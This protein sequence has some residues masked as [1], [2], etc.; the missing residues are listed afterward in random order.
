MPLHFWRAPVRSATTAS[1]GRARN[2]NPRPSPSGPSGRRTARLVEELR[3]RPR[4]GGERPDFRGGRQEV[5]GQLL[6]LVVRPDQVSGHHGVERGGHVDQAERIP[7]VGPEEDRPLERFG[8]RH[9]RQEIVSPGDLL[10]LEVVGARADELQPALVALVVER[11]DRP[12]RR[13]RGLRLLGVKRAEQGGER[14]EAEKADAH[15]QSLWRE[16]RRVT[17]PRRGIE[18]RATRAVALS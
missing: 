14:H 16:S 1:F 18:A 2:W 10:P 5:G 8:F 9:R 13:R 7:L 15:I 6:H 3:G 17:R 4:S 12:G 11:G